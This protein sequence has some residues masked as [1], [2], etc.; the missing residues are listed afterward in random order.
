MSSFPSFSLLC[1]SMCVAPQPRRLHV[2]L[3]G[4]GEAGSSES[5]SSSGAGAGLGVA[6]AVA[7]AVG[8]WRVGS[9]ACGAGREGSTRFAAPSTPF[10]FGAGSGAG[11]SSTAECGPVVQGGMLMNSSKVRTRDLQ[12]F[13]PVCQKPETCQLHILQIRPAVNSI[14]VGRRR[15]DLSGL[16]GRRGPGHGVSEIGD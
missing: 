10:C 7:V 15:T 16:R 3:A 11:V 5:S 2:A 12:H 13:Q 9:R 4:M 6:V 14:D 1:P 8:A